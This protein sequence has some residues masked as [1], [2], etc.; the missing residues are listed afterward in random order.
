VFGSNDEGQD[1]LSVFH[2]DG[3]VTI[4]RTDE[5]FFRVLCEDY[6]GDGSDDL[7]LGAYGFNPNFVVGAQVIYGSDITPGIEQ[8]APQTPVGVAGFT[9]TRILT[10]RL[11]GPTPRLVTIEPGTPNLMGTPDAGAVT[12]YDI[13][14]DVPV[15]LGVIFGSTE[16]ENFGN[17]VVV[18]DVDGDGT[19]EI[20]EIT[21]TEIRTWN[22]IDG[23]SDAPDASAA[24][25]FAA[26]FGGCE[27]QRG[28]V[29]LSDGATTGAYQLVDGEL[30]FI[31]QDDSLQLV[32]L[33]DAEYGE[34]AAGEL[35]KLEVDI[36]AGSMSWSPLAAFADI[37]G[38]SIADQV[39]P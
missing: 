30:I 20:T 39:L 26:T 17:D 35:V 31:A 7:V 3:M 32:D 16:L 11:D 10:G 38:N 34:T 24:L 36:E 6:D 28:Y 22:A 27:P 15:E 33:F 8:V 37:D 18:C 25:P 12:I 19:D 23:T 5:P 9:T 13:S 1:I 14:G 4:V 29:V 2:A 21:Q